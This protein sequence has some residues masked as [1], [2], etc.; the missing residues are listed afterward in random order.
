MRKTKNKSP[1][2]TNPKYS[3]TIRRIEGPH[4]RPIVL[5]YVIINDTND[6]TYGIHIGDV[7]YYGPKAFIHARRTLRHHITYQIFG[8]YYLAYLNYLEAVLKQ[9]EARDAKVL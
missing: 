5:R 6:K 8:D 7:N 1:V 4:Q 2:S 3:N 9:Y